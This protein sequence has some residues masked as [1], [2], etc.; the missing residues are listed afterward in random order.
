MSLFSRRSFIVSTLAG[1]LAKSVADLPN[2]A[3]CLNFGDAAMG[4]GEPSIRLRYLGTA[5]FVLE[6]G[7]HTLVLDPFVSRPRLCE[8]PFRLRPKT[9][10]ID[11]V[12]PHAD[13][14][15]VG[16]AHYDHILDAPYLCQRT[17]AR[18]IG[19]PSTGN[20]GRAAGL[21]ESQILCTMGN[22]I[23]ESGPTL[24]KGLP[25]LHGKVAGGRIPL[26][27]NIESPPSWPPRLRELRHGQ[28]LNWY[29]EV[30]GRRIVHIDS[31]DFID[32]ELEGHTADVVCL[33]AVGRRHR[34][35][36]VQTVVER[37]QPKIII[38][39][40]WDWL[41]TPYRAQPKLLPG[42]DLSGFVE[43]IESF[44][45]AAAVLP[46]DGEFVF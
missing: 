23:I 19:S 29:I 14:V 20:V 44:G 30:A 34:P 5:G 27:G 37:L 32:E 12:I 21:P 15:L 41:F 22:E 13:D 1:F 28:V 42:V 4:L 43:E 31:A 45:V 38:P 18:L 7:G 36:Y 46:F 40:H 35:K 25:S 17:G 26:P 8:M 10:L 16:H 33:C 6:S 24:I 3:K 2:A 11:E 9:Q 39:C